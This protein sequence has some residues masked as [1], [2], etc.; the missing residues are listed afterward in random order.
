MH[1]LTILASSLLLLTPLTFAGPTPIQA[2]NLSPGVS[3]AELRE[4]FSHA[5]KVI[6]AIVSIDR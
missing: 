6:S 1:F 3:D 4:V 5:G 2:A